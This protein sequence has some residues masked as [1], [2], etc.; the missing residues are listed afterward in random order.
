MLS[1][2]FRK[3]TVSEELLNFGNDIVSEFRIK[4]NPLYKDVICVPHYKVTVV[5]T[6][7]VELSLYLVVVGMAPVQFH[8]VPI[9][10]ETEALVSSTQA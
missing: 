2:H 8:I 4:Q 9:V 1:Q 3:N 7:N 10:D 6:H 5:S